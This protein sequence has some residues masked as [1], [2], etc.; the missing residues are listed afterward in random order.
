MDFHH[1]LVYDN[2]LEALVAATCW[3][4]FLVK[5]HDLLH[6]NAEAELTE[7]SVVTQCFFAH[8][9]FRTKNPQSWSHN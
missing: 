5:S 3:D 8:H 1:W 4:K 7:M 6:V 2:S 9:F